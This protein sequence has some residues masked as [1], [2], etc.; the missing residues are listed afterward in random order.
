[1]TEPRTVPHSLDAE[2][3]V[4]GAILINNT[5]YAQAAAVVTAADFFRLGHRRVFECIGG[6]LER[7]AAADLV[8]VAES[9]QRN[10]LLDEAG[11]PAYIASLVDG[12]PHSTNVEYYAQIVKEKARFRETIDVANRLSNRAYSA[13]E[14]SSEL[15][16]SAATEIAR[17][18]QRPTGGGLVLTGLD[19]LL[20]E[21]DDA[22]AWLVADRFA[23]GSV[24]LLAGR[25]KGGKS[26]IARALALSVARGEHWLES[27]CHQGHV[28]YVALEDKRS[29]VRRHMRNMGATGVESIRF[30]IGSAPRSLLADLA[31]LVASD[32]QI[33]LLIIDTA[34]RL[35][36]V[37]DTND[38][39][40]VTTAFEPVLALARTHGTCIV[41]LHHAGKSDRAGIESILGSTAWAASVDNVLLLNRTDRYRVL[42]SVQ[43]IGPDLPE[44]VVVMDDQ[45]GDVRLAGSRYLVDLQAVAAAMFDAV[46]AAGEIR[47]D[48]LLASI[49]ARRELKLKALQRLIDDPRV[50]RLGA[51]TKT[52]PHGYRIRREPASMTGTESDSG[53]RVPLKRREPESST[54]VYSTPAVADSG[55]QE[56][57]GS[58][59]QSPALPVQSGQPAPTSLTTATTAEEDT[60]TF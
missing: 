3:S 10:G 36:A 45:T 4:L 49:E 34:Q 12:V 7:G 57:V 16:A 47:R 43:R 40:L 37:R 38:Y 44:T 23:F 11:G 32:D 60:W 14:H 48:D 21:P 25:P 52:S 18:A 39:A 19:M 29:E 15:L 51:G 30:L 28:V 13:D 17:L 2:K 22:V 54:S 58:H 6:L 35:L 1:M 33:D 9:L 27:R 56:R 8:T 20:A 42:S 53:S 41:L 5:V 46:A 55:S 31:A 59:E 26:T 50:E 24:N